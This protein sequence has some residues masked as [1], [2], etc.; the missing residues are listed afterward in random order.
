MKYLKP[1]QSEFEATAAWRS[2]A[3]RTRFLQALKRRKI[4]RMQV[5]AAVTSAEIPCAHLT[6]TFVLR[7]MHTQYGSL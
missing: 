6:A 2:Q 3:E 4:Y 7:V 1:V 5:I